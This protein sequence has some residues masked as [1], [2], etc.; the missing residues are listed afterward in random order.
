[1]VFIK[2]EWLLI[3]IFAVVLTGLMVKFSWLFGLVD[4]PDERRTHTLP[5][6]RGGGLAIALIFTSMVFQPIYLTAL[7][8]AAMG[9]WDDIKN[10]S[11]KFRFLLQFLIGGF[12]LYEFNGFQAI[13][14]FGLAIPMLC[15]LIFIVWMTN[16]YNFMDGING[17]AGLEA[18]FFSLSMAFLSKHHLNE[19]FV[20]ASASLG[21]LVWNFPK[22]K[23]FLGDVGSQFFGFL[24][25]L[26]LVREA[27]HSPVHFISGLIL[28]GVF[29][30]DATFTLMTRILTKQKFSQAHRSHAYQILWKKF[31]S[32]HAKVTLLMMFV[33]VF[34]LLPWAYA[35]CYGYVPSVLGLLI[36]YLPLV[37]MCLFFKAGRLVS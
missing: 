23:I 12:A 13:Q 37:I 20:L 10:L 1:M 30:V 34:W 6:P 17:L 3:F 5:T 33:N 9:F 15:F 21:F 27:A 8:I 2:M 28:M 4:K 35:V 25:A 16:L 29:L 7:A 11:A 31:N 22:A 19:W 26:M 36:S 18:V 32:S 24:F 14:L